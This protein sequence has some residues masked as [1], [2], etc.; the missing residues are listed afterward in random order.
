MLILHKFFHKCKNSEC[1]R[2]TILKTVIFLI[3]SKILTL[4]EIIGKTYK[5]LTKNEPKTYQKRT[6]NEP[7]TNQKQ[8][9]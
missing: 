3:L 8:A 2:Q 1:F 7:K 4:K 5:K 9:K 6:K